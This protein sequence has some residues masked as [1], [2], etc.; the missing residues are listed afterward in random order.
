RAVTLATSLGRPLLVLEAFRSDTRYACARFHRFVLD[1]MADQAVR[2]ASVGVAYYPYVEP[3]PG[4]GKGLLAALAASAC[5][6]VTD[7][8]PASFQPR[9]RA[10]AAK[11][12]DVRLE[13]VDGSGLL[14]RAAIRDALDDPRAFRARFR[15]ALPPVAFAGAVED[16]L[17][18][19]PPRTLERLPV[20][21]A[22]RWHPV[23]KA[24][25][26]GDPDLLA[27]FRVDA[28]VGPVALRGGEVAAREAFAAALRAPAAA[29]A[30]DLDAWLR[31]G[32]LSAEEVARTLL[33]R[34][35][36]IASVDLVKD[37]VVDHGWWTPSPAVDGFLEH[38]VLRREHAL[39]RAERRGRDGD[40]YVALPA[41][42]RA[43]LE[44]AAAVPGRVCADV[45]ALE[46]GAG[47][48]PAWN[49]LQH[50][51][52]TEGRLPV[53][54]RWRW[55]R[56]LLEATP[57]PRDAF[58]LAVHLTHKY[59][60]DGRDP[61]VIAALTEV[62]VDAVAPRE[63]PGAPAAGG[64]KGGRPA[65]GRKA[66]RAPQ[67]RGQPRDRTP[68]DAKPQGPRGRD[69]SP[70]DPQRRD[71]RPGGPPRPEAGPREPRPGGP[72]GPR[73]PRDPRPPPPS[74]PP[75]APPRA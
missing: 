42:V 54:A 69:P 13:A 20:E 62:F 65:K 35:G 68:R 43:R 33:L 59:A 3:V 10:A 57:D 64:P 51:L 70:Q 4:A 27:R 60:L 18:T 39:H 67:G 12:L 29:F 5:A 8:S 40:R 63:R 15:R 66:P 73:P 75:S 74:A 2:F 44:R 58:D 34:D 45:A 41:D 31:F 19:P 26:D 25:L 16:P 7:A 37:A 61:A 36:R 23:R 52:R 11:R 30:P 56:G 49:A 22:D 17:A 38:V 48:D 71:A 1:G 6:V 24:L 72:T 28:A 50:A 53:G 47:P 21:V 32:H 14:P 9:M 46:A 55:T